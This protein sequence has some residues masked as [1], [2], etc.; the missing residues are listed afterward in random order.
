MHETKT[1]DI[2]IGLHSTKVV[3]NV[4]PSLTNLSSLDDFG[5]FYTIHKWIS[6]RRIFYHN[7]KTIKTNDE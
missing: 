1:L 7:T 3:L 5:L 2:T 4:I 6:I